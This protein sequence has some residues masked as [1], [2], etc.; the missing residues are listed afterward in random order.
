M[1]LTILPKILFRSYLALVTAQ[2]KQPLVTSAR[3]GMSA[4]FPMDQSVIANINYFYP[5]HIY[6]LYVRIISSVPLWSLNFSNHVF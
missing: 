5:R 4:L 6:L 3:R 2:L 1:L